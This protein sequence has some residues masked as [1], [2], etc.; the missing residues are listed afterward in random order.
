MEMP[1]LSRLKLLTLHHPVVQPQQSTYGVVVRAVLTGPETA[2]S[3]ADTGEV[4][5]G[6]MW[7][8]DDPRWPGA[9]EDQ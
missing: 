9:G 6:G 2:E 4:F 1:R 5:E 3:A 8:D 7:K